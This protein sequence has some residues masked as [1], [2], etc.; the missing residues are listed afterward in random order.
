MASMD[1]TIWRGL[2]IAHPADWELSVASPA[3]KDG[4][5]V[6]ADRYF[7]RLEVFWRPIRPGPTLGML[8]EKFRDEHIKGV[9]KKIKEA[10]K[11][12]GK[13]AAPPDIKL[14]PLTDAPDGWAGFIQKLPKGSITRA[15]RLADEDR[16]LIEVAV[17]WPSRRDSAAEAEILRNMRPV[18]R[19]QDTRRR[20]AMGLDVT[21]PAN[22]ELELN[23]PSAGRIHWEFVDPDDEKYG[24]L[25]IERL[26]MA[27]AWMT[28]TLAEW[29]PKNLIPNST[30][31][32]Q[33]GETVNGHPAQTCLSRSP[34]GRFGSFWGKQNVRSETIWICPREDRMYRL[35]LAR[36]SRETDLDLPRPLT[37]A[38][39][40]PS[41][42]IPT[43]EAANAP[44]SRRRSDTDLPP[45][46][47][48]TE[49]FL[50]AV[51]FVNQEMNVEPGNRGG[52]LVQIEM[53]RPKFM[54][55][56]ISWIFPYG[57]YRQVQLDPTGQAVLDLCNGSRPVEKIIEKFAATHK[58]TFREA[59]LPVTGYLRQLTQR[60]IVAIVGLAEDG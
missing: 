9:D 26:A 41:E 51:P 23:R 33:H 29:L 47:K 30:V 18:A 7:Q 35:C 8:V 5:C 49:D 39:C 48:T 14:Q 32:H 53:E 46:V 27:S 52:A 1:R 54:I 6:F 20:R 59:Q 42:A 43:L 31:I 45:A 15:L 4:Q 21:L 36:V 17:V 40:A 13:I 19:D 2:E 24:R 37:V 16:L 22:L 56:P 11:S 58:L 55:P 57:K 3:G 28:D 12:K 10:K 25:F 60:G 44:L 38:C 34:V 50:A